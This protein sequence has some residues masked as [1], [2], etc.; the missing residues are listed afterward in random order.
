[1]NRLSGGFPSNRHNEVRDLTSGFPI[2]VCHDV[3]TEPTLQPLQGEHLKYKS[4]NGEVGARLDV[5]AHNFWGEK[6]PNC[7]L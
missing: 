7:L 5:A 2:E 3:H 6:P 1:M 4:A